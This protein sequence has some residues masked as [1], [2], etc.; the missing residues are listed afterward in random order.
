[1]NVLLLIVGLGIATMLLEVVHLRKLILPVVT[2]GLLAVI[3]ISFSEIYAIK[4]QVLSEQQTAYPNAFTKMLFFD[5]TAWTNIIIL[6]FAT[7]CWI[8]MHINYLNKAQHLS[9]F[10]ALSLFVLV[11]GVVLV[12]QVN[13]T[14]L[15]LGVEIVSIPVY[16]MVGSNK[17]DLWSNEAAFKYFI[18][19]SFASCFMLLGIALIY[20]TTGTFETRFIGL[21]VQLSNSINIQL[22][23]FGLILIFFTFAVKVA[24]VPFHFWSPDAYAG[25]PTPFTAFMAVIVKII[26]LAAAFRV[27][28]ILF[29][30]L[31]LIYVNIVLLVAVLS[32]VVGNI[33]GLTQTN[34]KKLLAYSG[35]S[36]A[37]FVLLSFTYLNY[38]V[39]SVAAYYFAAYALSGLLAF[40][41]M[42]KTNEN[43]ID[44]TID[45]YKGLAFRNPLLAIGMTT[46]L[47]SMAGIPPLAGFFAKY[48]IL[49]NLI[50]SGK[51]WVA[52]VA[53]LASVIAVVYYLR[54]VITMYQTTDEASKTPIQINWLNKIGIILLIALNI[55]FGIYPSIILNIFN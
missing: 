4:H 7:L 39:N 26:F 22:L 23:Y 20:G 9:D 15:F 3:G 51:L 50:L 32:I 46:A 8:I 34:I 47:L 17:R 45:G 28:V 30:S 29:G 42:A 21:M 2:I 10:I 25:A 18:I 55:L 43:N 54:V 44:E 31:N 6:S 49:S 24:A 35:I 41:I 27:F 53:I 1:M 40:W 14:M 16:I 52:V 37:G 38:N 12:A 11:G 36:H 48:F 19:G 33:I 13:F 5:I